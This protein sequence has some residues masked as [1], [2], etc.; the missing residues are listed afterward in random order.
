MWQLETWSSFEGD[1][2]K[3]LTSQSGLHQVIKETTHILGTSSSSSSSSSSDDLIFMSQP[4]LII[5]SGLHWSLYSNCHHQIIFS[6][7]NLDAVYPP[8]SVREVWHYKDAD[9]NLIRQVI[10]KFNWQ[11]A[12]LNTNYN[13]KVG[14]FNSTILNNLSNFILHE[15][16]VCDSKESMV[17]QE[18][19][20]IN[21]R[22][23]CCI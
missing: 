4:N 22:K 19:K 20:R 23:K 2:I 13:E 14:I 5:E 6:K 21:P 9:T 10:N 3:N 15:F 17:Q 12:F 8:P 7:F 18:N 16:V 1:A 11:R